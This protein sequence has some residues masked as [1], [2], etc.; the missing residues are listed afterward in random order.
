NARRISEVM[1]Q[2][3]G[4]P[5]VEVPPSMF[6]QTGKVLIFGREPVRIDVLT[7]AS[8]VNFSECYERR[9]E[10]E[11]DGV[12]VP[13]ISLE[14]LKQNKRASDRLKDR[15]DLENLPPRRAPGTKSKRRR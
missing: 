15:A 3:G 14:D 8:G 9:I 5:A 11:L 6:L 2:F 4:F 10:G 1:Q 13:L 12:V 7:S